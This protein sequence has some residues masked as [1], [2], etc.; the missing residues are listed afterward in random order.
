MLYT[1]SLNF[2]TSFSQSITAVY[3]ICNLNDYKVES[4]LWQDQL[5]IN[6]Q[7]DKTLSLNK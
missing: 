6:K 1:T 3:K 2:P 7:M 4:Y 5:K